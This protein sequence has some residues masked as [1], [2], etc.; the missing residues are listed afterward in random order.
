MRAISFSIRQNFAAARLL[1]EKGHASDRPAAPP[2]RAAASPASPSLA[3]GPGRLSSG[4]GVVTPSSFGSGADVS[5][6]HDVS[7]GH[8]T[9]A[10]AGRS[11]GRGSERSTG[12]GSERVSPVSTPSGEWAPA[13]TIV[14]LHAR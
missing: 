3:F 10:S 5:S 1:Y 12:R 6:I 9:D 11:A 13:A 7:S 14:V 2:G 8:R 4:A